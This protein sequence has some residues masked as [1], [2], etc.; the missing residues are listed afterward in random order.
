MRQR[1]I[2]NGGL[3][4]A[5]LLACALSALEFF[6]GHPQDL[7]GRLGICLP[8]PNLWPIPDRISWITN[9]VL[10]IF[11]GLALHFFNKTYNFISSSDTIPSA[12]F[13]F[14]CGANPWI[15]GLL[16]SSLL[17]MGANLICLNLLFNCY[18]SPKGMEQ[19]FVVGVILALGSMM[20]YG[21]IFMIPAYLLISATLK[22]LHLRSFIAYLMGLVTP[23]WIGIGLGLI[24]LDVLSYPSI[25]NLF[26]D[27]A[28]KQ[29]LLVG[30]LNG[31]VT[32]LIMVLLILSNAVKLYAGNTRRRLMNNSIV[33]LGIIVSACMICDVDNV[34]AYFA[35]LYF[36]VATQL[37]NFFVLH[38][39]RHINTLIF[40]FVALYLVAYFFMIIGY[41]PALL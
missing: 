19:M 18:R 22:C 6:V 8:S 27:F 33:I 10:L 36:V 35:T 14:L 31:A 20:E 15:S 11:L 39:V 16:T 30:L 4:I 24:P 29:S 13:I 25:T 37:A 28:T 2:G 23:Y 3:W 41:L 26:E 5:V 17:L 21:F 1:I 38:N 7:E 9:L 32:I 12:A 34:T 40:V